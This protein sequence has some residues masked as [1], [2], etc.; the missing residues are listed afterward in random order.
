MAPPHRLGVHLGIQPE[1]A[2]PSAGRRGAPVART[3]SPA[4]VRIE[5]K[6]SG[7]RSGPP[8]ARRLAQ[9]LIQAEASCGPPGGKWRG[10]AGARP[11]G[12]AGRQV[13]IVKV[14]QLAAGS[15][16]AIPPGL[17]HLLQ[18]GT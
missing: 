1:A 10:G 17:R 13:I 3:P 9:V 2:L 15:S 16:R 6:T 11:A 18:L 12:A 4:E 7:P 14:L 5:A 8:A